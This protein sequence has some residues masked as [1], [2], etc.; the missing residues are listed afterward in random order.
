MLRA[1]ALVS[2]PTIS[3]ADL[4]PWLRPPSSIHSEVS[5]EIPPEGLDLEHL[6]NGLERGFLVKALERARGVKKDAAH[7]LK[8]NARSFRYRLEKY[9]IGRGS[10]GEERSADDEEGDE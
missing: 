7:L 3:L 10:G 8:L 9:G 1:V 6:I 2:G 4:E 5:S